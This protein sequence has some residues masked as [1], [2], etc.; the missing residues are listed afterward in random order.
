MLYSLPCHLYK[1]SEILTMRSLE[2]WGDWMDGASAIDL[3][4]PGSSPGLVMWNYVVLV[5]LWTLGDSGSLIWMPPKFRHIGISWDMCELNRWLCS[6]LCHQAER[7]SISIGISWEVNEYRT[8]G[9]C[10]QDLEVL[11]LLAQWHVPKDIGAGDKCHSCIMRS[12]FW[13]CVVIFPGFTDFLWLQRSSGQP[14]SCEERTRAN[15]HVSEH[16][17]G[18]QRFKQSGPPVDKRQSRTGIS[19]VN[20]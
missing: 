16:A 18:R 1:V 20:L 14:G 2:I 6:C 5:K 12:R 3:C 9:T 17:A 19:T 4:D 8:C 11:P 10:F 13:E 7:C 15:D